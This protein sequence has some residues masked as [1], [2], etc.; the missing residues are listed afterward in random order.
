LSEKG[1]GVIVIPAL[2]NSG[3]TNLCPVRTSLKYLDTA[4][5]VSWALTWFLGKVIPADLYAN[6]TV[7]QIHEEMAFAVMSFCPCLIGAKSL[8]ESLDLTPKA[9]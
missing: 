8:F 6:M 2:P 4:F 9:V 5:G 7:L 3:P 1:S